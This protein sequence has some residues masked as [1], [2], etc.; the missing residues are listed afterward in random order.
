[1]ELEQHIKF[2]NDFRR[3]LFMNN[4]RNYENNKWRKMEQQNDNQNEECFVPTKNEDYFVPTKVTDVNPGEIVQIETEY[5][6]IIAEVIVPM[7][8]EDSDFENRLMVLIKDKVLIGFTES[9]ILELYTFKENE[10]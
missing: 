9:E 2:T 6:S 3:I 7:I 5:A 1:M 10:A 8:R 4:F